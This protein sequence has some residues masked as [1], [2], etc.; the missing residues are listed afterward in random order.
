[1][2]L[3]NGAGSTLQCVQCRLSV[4]RVSTSVKLDTLIP[5]IQST[6]VSRQMQ[7]ESVCTEASLQLNRASI[8][9]KKPFSAN[10]G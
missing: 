1:M 5:T 4:T 3:G 6:F 9:R 10:T 7:L 8:E 2:G